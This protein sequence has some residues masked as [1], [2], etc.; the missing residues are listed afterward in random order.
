MA[1]VAEI[2]VSNCDAFG[3]ALGKVRK[4]LGIRAPQLLFRGQSNSEWKLE[5]TLERAGCIAMYFREYYELITS[6]IAAA[7]G[8]FSDVKIPEYSFEVS[9]VF[10]DIQLFSLHR[11]PKPDLY[12]Y[13]VYLRHHGFPSPLLDWSR[14]PYV[15]AFF[16]FRDSPSNSAT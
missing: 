3:A 4:E 14:S 12:S 7:V 9:A 11:F 1:P 10:K 8:S 15:A 13:M 5:T 2:E 16:A 6:S